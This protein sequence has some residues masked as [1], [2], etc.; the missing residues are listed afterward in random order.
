MT[1]GGEK[2]VFLLSPSAVVSPLTPVSRPPNDLPLR[3]PRMHH[4]KSERI[5]KVLRFP[6]KAENRALLCQFCED[7]TPQK[8]TVMCS[9]CDFRYCG[10]CFDACHPSK[11]PLASHTVSAPV[12][13]SLRKNETE[14]SCAEHKKE[15]LALYCVPCEAA[16]CY[17]CKECGGHRGHEVELLEG[18]FKKA[19]VTAE[20]QSSPFSSTT[21][22]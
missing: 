16:V 9:E 21:N 7:V 4:H 22:G 6:G 2:A 13:K 3:S 10:T 1:E 14:L 17:L 11:G 18:V 20:C 5:P 8:A 19:K 12:E 15:K